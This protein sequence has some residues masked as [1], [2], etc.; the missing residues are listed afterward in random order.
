[1]GS[2]HGAFSLPD[3]VKIQERLSG[4]L[5]RA[6]AGVDDARGEALGEKLRRASRTVPQDD[7]VGVIGLEDFCGVLKRFAFRQ[8]G[9]TRRNVDDIRAQT[10]RR[11]LERSPRARARLDE[12]IYERLAAERRHFFDF[13]R[14]DFLE[15]VGGV[16]NEDDF[17][18]GELANPEQIFAL[19]AHLR[20]GGL[21]HVFSSFTTQTASG[22]LSTF[23]SRNRTRSPGA[24]GKF[25]PT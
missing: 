3:R 13:A 25:L 19:P 9:R 20:L 16:E 17:L 15:R 23:S 11:D 12:K 6:V 22:S 7:E 14:A 8:A 2:R 5:V 21:R 4:M 10:D 24:V 1:M 18:R